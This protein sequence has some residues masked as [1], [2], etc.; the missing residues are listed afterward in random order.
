M[1]FALL[2]DGVS[3]QNKLLSAYI[4]Q[5]ATDKFIVGVCVV[6][7]P[8]F[9]L[10]SLLTPDANHDGFALC[11]QK[12]IYR[13]EYDSQYLSS[14]SQVNVPQMHSFDNAGSFDA[15]YSY[16]E[17]RSTIVH[18]LNCRGE[19]LLHGIPSRHNE[20]TI[21]IQQVFADGHFGNIRKIKKETVGVLFWDSQTEKELQ[22]KMEN[23][24]HDR[25]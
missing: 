1:Y 25:L 13:I 2:N 4:K 20:K 14:I 12:A 23:Y 22:S 9:I 8:D 19:T 16:L 24:E 11:M 7:N 17:N 3:L 21:E 18:L 5:R 10:L 15:L 6:Q